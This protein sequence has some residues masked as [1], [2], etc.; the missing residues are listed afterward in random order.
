MFGRRT[1]A[2]TVIVGAS[3]FSGGAFAATHRTHHEA[4]TKPAKVQVNQ[5]LTRHHCHLSS[6]A[7]IA[8]NV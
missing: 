3:A 6:G 1:V 2:V 7:G 5:H 8:G 4:K